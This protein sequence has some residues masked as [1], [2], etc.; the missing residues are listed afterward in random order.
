MRAAMC[1][2]IESFNPPRIFAPISPCRAITVHDFGDQRWRASSRA[3]GNHRR[4]FPGF[5]APG[6]T[7]R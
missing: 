1:R 3:Y 4:Q 2:S 5:G 7:E 6:K